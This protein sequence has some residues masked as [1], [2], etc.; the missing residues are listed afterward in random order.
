MI[1]VF[2]SS[3][4]IK[5]D[6][7]R[8]DILK[9]ILAVFVVGIHTMPIIFWLRPLFR[10][11][12]PLFF[13]MSSYFFFLKQSKISDLQEKKKAHWLFVKRIVWL[14]LFWTLVLLPYIIYSGE[15]CNFSLPTF[16]K[17][18]KSFFI[19]GIFPASW[20][21][22]STVISVSVIYYFSKIFSNRVL[23]IGSMLAYFFCCLT[24]NYLVLFEKL[25]LSVLIYKSYAFV[26]GKPCNSFLSAFLFVIFG[27]IL[28]ENIFIIRNKWLVIIILAS[29]VSL[30]VEAEIIAYFRLNLSKVDY[31]DDCFF[32]LVPLCLSSFM[33]LGQNYI[34]IPFKTLF[35]RFS[36]TIIYCSHFTV[37]SILCSFVYS[38]QRGFLLFSVV[39]L[40][41]CSL[42]FLICSLED[43][44]HYTWL[45]Y[46]H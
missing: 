29:F 7:R 28:A 27:K 26:L 43:N 35:L 42:C 36:S 10:I 15:W 40:I 38:F 17:V 30:F 39:L 1:Q 25:P 8:F 2:N 46:A 18:L 31:S 41:S 6:G 23:L 9:I 19:S 22:T 33:L 32:S 45:K 14:Y 37:S 11:A 4:Y 21:L 34:I 44:R 13:M 12:V 20:Y 16:L 3:D 5:I 24:S